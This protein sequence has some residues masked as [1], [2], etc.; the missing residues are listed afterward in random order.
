M[1]LGFG[2]EGTDWK[3]GDTGL[4]VVVVV[5]MERRARVRRRG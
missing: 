2:E 4:A 5:S 3:R 1:M